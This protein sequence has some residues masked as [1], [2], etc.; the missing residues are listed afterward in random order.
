MCKKLFNKIYISFLLILVSLVWAG[1]FVAVKMTVR[2]ISPIDLGFLRF[3]VASPFMFVILITTKKNIIIPIKEFIYISVLGL[4]GVTLLYIFQFKGIELTT[5]STSAVLI[6]TNVIFIVLLSVY[7]LKEKFALKKLIGVALSFLG[8]IIVVFAQMLNE[9]IIFNRIFFIGCILIIISAL[10]WAIYSIIGKILLGK[11][12]FLTITTYAFIFGTIFFLPVVMPDITYVI[13]NISFNG[14]ITIL[15]L[16]L[17]CSVFGY[18][19]WYHALSKIDAGKAAVFL[20][21]IPL[22]TIF[23][24]F[25][26][27]EVPTILFIIGAIILIWGVY[28]AQK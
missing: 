23:I 7:F 2:E 8:V 13:Q 4:T 12:D 11:Y 26:S 28:L 21:L 17:I 20:N 25:F 27:G 9:S 1:S 5:A 24:S 16:S 10:C 18:V 14:W 6:N 15:Y 3:L 22:F 19:A